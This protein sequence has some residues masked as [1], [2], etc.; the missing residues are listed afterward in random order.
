MRLRYAIGGLALVA[1]LALPA[2]ASAKAAHG[3]DQV[4]GLAAQQCGQERSDIGKRAFRRKYGVKRTMQSCVRRT[5]PQ[6]SAAVPTATS[7]CQ[8]EL[9][10]ETPADFIDEYGDD[11]ST[12][13]ADAMTECV[14][15]D[16]DQILNPDAYV[17]D[18][19]DN[20]TGA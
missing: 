9:A 18:P 11:A 8:D 12:P 7:D 6:V 17:E 19:T 15:E 10:A 2:G 14:A 1:L 4:T 13:L 20:V 16:V 5:E 3:S